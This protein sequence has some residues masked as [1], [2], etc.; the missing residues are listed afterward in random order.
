MTCHPVSCIEYQLGSKSHLTSKDL[1]KSKGNLHP[2]WCVGI[3]TLRWTLTWAHAVRISLPKQLELDHPV[4]SSL[5]VIA[6]AHQ[7]IKDTTFIV[8]THTSTSVTK[9]KRCTRITGMS[10]LSRCTAPSRISTNP[11]TNTSTR[12]LSSK[13]KS[14]SSLRNTWS[15]STKTKSAQS[16]LSSRP[17]SDNL[18][19]LMLVSMLQHFAKDSLT[20]TSPVVHCL[21]SLKAS[22]PIIPRKMLLD[23]TKWATNL[24][25]RNQKTISMWLWPTWIYLTLSKLSS[26]HKDCKYSSRGRLPWVM[27]RLM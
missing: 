8:T 22:S 5:M 21:T 11:L 17:I 1:S 4:L 24:W 20:S 18:K 27:L 19:K 12:T 3:P 2:I 23:L 13:I 26:S 14:S 6:V 10:H 9:T 15:T 7:L 16:S 25:L